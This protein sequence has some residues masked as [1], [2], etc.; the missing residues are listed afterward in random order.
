MR[1]SDGAEGEARGSAGATESATARRRSTGTAWGFYSSL[2]LCLREN[3]QHRSCSRSNRGGKSF[4]GKVSLLLYPFSFQ[5]RSPWLDK[6]ASVGP[7]KDPPGPG[8]PMP[9]PHCQ[10]K[11][12]RGSL[13][14]A[15]IFSPAKS[16]KL[17]GNSQQSPWPFHRAGVWLGLTSKDLSGCAVYSDL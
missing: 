3:L 17:P 14:W 2:S 4:P 1:H 13:G 12:T 16:S 8:W 9:P 15:L 11:G 7:R 10:L 5:P 6:P